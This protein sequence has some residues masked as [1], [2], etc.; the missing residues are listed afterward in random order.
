MHDHTPLASA[1]LSRRH[2]LH[3]LD[4]AWPSKSTWPNTTKKLTDHGID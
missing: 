4:T 3:G 2:L 1:T